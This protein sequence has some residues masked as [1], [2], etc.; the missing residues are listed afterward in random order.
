[1]KRAREVAPPAAVLRALEQMLGE[2]VGHVR[3]I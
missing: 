2:P 3:V 1:M